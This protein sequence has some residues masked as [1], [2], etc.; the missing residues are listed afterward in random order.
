MYCR[1]QPWGAESQRCLFYKCWYPSQ[2]LCSQRVQEHTWSTKGSSGFVRKQMNFKTKNISYLTCS[3]LPPLCPAGGCLGQFIILI[4]TR[5]Q[6]NTNCA[7]LRFKTLHDILQ[8]GY[9]ATFGVFTFIVP[10]GHKNVLHFIECTDS[11][12]PSDTLSNPPELESSCFV[13]EMLLCY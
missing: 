6:S 13:T 3:T 2:L 9:I 7:S 11:E 8:T 12:T 10:Q 5:R 1:S 4:R